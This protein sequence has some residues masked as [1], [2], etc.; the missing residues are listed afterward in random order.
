MQQPKN[1]R[2]AARASNAELNTRETLRKPTVYGSKKPLTE[3]PD[4]VS[5]KSPTKAKVLIVHRIGFVRAGVISLI[6]ESMQFVVCG[7]TD[8]A[9]LARELFLRHNPHLVVVGLR[10]TGADGIQ[11]IKEFRSLNPAAPILALSE[12]AD[13]FS[14]QRAF[15]AGARGCLSIEDAPELLRALDEISSGRPFV[16]A[17]VLPLILNNF[18]GGAKSV[19]SSDINSLS[20]RELEIFSFI[21]R[22]LSV[23][24]LASELNVSV[25]TIETHQMRMKEKLGLHSAAELRRKARE[26]LARSALNRIREDPESEQATGARFRCF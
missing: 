20:N 24:E 21:G 12:Q 23:S 22:G 17:S 15:R 10:L 11:V 9:P 4:G 25:K 19:G 2:H 1:E 6:G 8:G 5:G 18:A 16:G 3:E 26:W 7:E 13:A 14:A